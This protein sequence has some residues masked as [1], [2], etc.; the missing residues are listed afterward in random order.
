MTINTRRYI[1]NKLTSRQNNKNRNENFFYTVQVCSG[2]LTS[3]CEG[4]IGSREQGTV[5]FKCSFCWWEKAIWEIISCSPV[6]TIPWWFLSL[7]CL[8]T[9][10]KFIV[11]MLDVS[12][13][14][15]VSNTEG[16]LSNNARFLLICASVQ[17]SSFRHVAS[18]VLATWN[19]EEIY[20]NIC[21]KHIHVPKVTS[22]YKTIDLSGSQN[23]T[24][25]W[26]RTNKKL[27]YLTDLSIKHIQMK[28]ICMYWQHK[29]KDGLLRKITYW[30]ITE[31]RIYYIEFFFKC[32]RR[33][34]QEVVIFP[35]LQIIHVTT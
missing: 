4:S 25:A 9:I 32:I 18:A 31:I 1:W 19:N 35:H 22:L 23:N 34:R 26:I 6:P 20:C 13:Y 10:H 33:K 8:M 2:S 5:K 24:S 12:S 3:E 21:N 27:I 30:V 29:D 17:D 11:M 14:M 16:S 15:V 7:Y 28:N